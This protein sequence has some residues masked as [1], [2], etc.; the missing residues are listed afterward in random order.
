MINDED[1]SNYESDINI[2]DKEPRISTPL[3]KKEV[4]EP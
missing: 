3:L 4:V 1:S 2:N